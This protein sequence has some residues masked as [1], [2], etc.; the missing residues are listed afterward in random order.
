MSLGTDAATIGVL[1]AAAIVAV[2]SLIVFA[3]ASA[4]LSSFLSLD[5]STISPFGEADEPK[6]YRIVRALLRRASHTAVALSSLGYLSFSAALLLV[7]LIIYHTSGI[8]MLPL[9]WQAL[10]SAATIL[11]LG[12]IFIYVGHTLPLMQLSSSDYVIKNAPLVRFAYGIMFP[13]SALLVRLASASGRSDAIAEAMQLEDFGVYE[14]TA[15]VEHELEEEEREMISAIVEMGE[16]TV[17]EIMTPRIDI[18]ALDADDPAQESI[19]SILDSTYSRFPVYE[20]TVD[21]I[22]GVLH[23]RDLTIELNRKRPDEINIRQLA[24]ETLYIPETKRIDELLQD[25]RREKKHLVIV[26]D[27]YGGTAGIVTIE[28]VLEEI[29]GEI[30]D[31]YDDEAAG[32]YRKEDGSFVINP[33]LPIEEVNEETGL[34]LDAEGSDTLGGLLLDKFGRIP[35]QGDVIHIDG[36]RF[37][38]LSVVKNRIK[39]VRAE[40]KR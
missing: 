15:P 33:S 4:A 9:W 25:L 8:E 2:G 20:G 40:I 5:P 34:E 18:V 10:A 35:R 7:Y 39:L 12:F 36:V 30:Q 16:T 29:V 3:F 32:V 28:D 17:R 21:N 13:A 31:E 6:N 24:Q 19:K 22:I 37:T 27:E 38:I 11:V 26:T 23:I 14:E 1:T